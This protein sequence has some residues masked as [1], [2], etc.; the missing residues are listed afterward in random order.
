MASK[1]II[2]YHLE[3]ESWVGDWLSL[4]KNNLDLFCH[5]YLS[6]EMSFEMQ[7]SDSF[8]GNAEYVCVVTNAKTANVLRGFDCRYVISLGRSVTV[9]AGYEIYSFR[10]NDDELNGVPDSDYWQTLTDLAFSLAGTKRE[11]TLKVYLGAVE[12]DQQKN[13]NVL[14]Q[15]LK[16]K[17]YSVS[18]PRIVSAEAEDIEREIQNSAQGCS[19]AVLFV[20]ADQGEA[21]QGTEKGLVEFQYTALQAYSRN[22]AHIP[23]LLW[24]DDLSAFQQSESLPYLQRMLNFA[25]S[26]S[27][28]EAVQMPIAKFKEIVLKRIVASVGDRL[29]EAKSSVVSDNVWY[30]MG[31]FSKPC[32]AESLQ[33][34]RHS[35]SNV[36]TE[37]VGDPESMI[38]NHLSALIATKNILIST[39]GKSSHWLH[40]KMQDVLKSLGLGRTKMFGV[41]AVLLHNSDE[42]FSLVLERYKTLLPLKEFGCSN[43]ET[44][45]Q[46]VEKR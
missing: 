34:L 30:A 22:I 18:V 15:E 27:D 16:Q 19:L 36:L 14:L 9:P 31:D 21:V 5:C 20:G 26:A 10:G 6:T 37:I 40:S 44:L 24:F 17:Q 13:K 41:V 2:L 1:R 39:Q 25:E 38:D 46:I 23:I 11:D 43:T 4:L 42:D 29:V 33:I 28:T 12:A 32:C 35:E 3:S 45:M 8:D 7:T